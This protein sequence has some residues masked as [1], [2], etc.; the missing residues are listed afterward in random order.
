MKLHFG[1]N[2][3]AYSDPGVKGATTTGEVAQILEDKYSVMEV[4]WEAHKEEVIQSVGNALQERIE[5][6]LQGNRPKSGQVKI[7]RAEVMF[8][9]YLNNDEWQSMKGHVIA[10]AMG[11]VNL[12]KKDKQVKGARP[13]FIDTGL[14]QQSARIWLDDK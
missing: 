7:D 1:V 2:E 9:Q 4:F 11:G 12:R 8:R 10:A 6:I 5:S 13:A 14:Y 3:V